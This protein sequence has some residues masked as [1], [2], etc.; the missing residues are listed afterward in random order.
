MDQRKSRDTQYLAIFLLLLALLFTGCGSNMPKEYKKVCK[1]LAGRYASDFTVIDSSE[2]VLLCTDAAGLVNKDEHITVRKT[3]NGYVDDYALFFE[4]ER[5]N[6]WM[7]DL[8]CEQFMDVRAFMVI[9]GTSTPQELDHDCELDEF[10]SL[11]PTYC[12]KS[13]VFVAVDDLEDKE[14]FEKRARAISDVL[15]SSGRTFE[16]NVYCISIDSL[17]DLTSE[18]VTTAKEVAKYSC[19]IERQQ[20]VKGQEE[21]ESEDEAWESTNAPAT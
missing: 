8:F 14:D 3:E 19:V 2:D 16:I 13:D 21:G 1:Y 11:Y 5:F 18:S 9:D 10:F 6:S 20:E 7:H 17:I 12:I 4:R 15:Y